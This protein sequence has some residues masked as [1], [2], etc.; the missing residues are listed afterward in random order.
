MADIITLKNGNSVCK[1][2]T[3]GAELISYSVNGKEKIWQGGG[4]FWA[5]KSP[6]LFPVC[7]RLV[8]G[9][10]NYEGNRYPLNAHG[11]IR[12]SN[13][14]VV[15]CETQTATFLFE[16]NEDTLKIYPFE[17]KFRVMY[18]LSKTSLGVYFIIENHSKVDMYYSAGC[19]EGYALSGDLSEYALSFDGGESEIQNTILKNNFTT[20]QKE[21]IKLVDGTL[22]L[23]DYFTQDNDGDSLII[24]N[25]NSKRVTLLRDGNEEISVYFGDFNHLVLWTQYGAPF[26]AIEPW[27]GLPDAVDTNHELSE[28]LSIEKLSPNESKTLYHSITVIE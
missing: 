19:H 21:S 27:N 11:F 25:V 1:I 6:I 12:N 7:G 9:F 4:K 8:D 26:F 3:L 18:K 2:S 15:N 22:K 13:F 20:T 14:S 24:E 10:Y 16:S 23:S 17:F 5:G 28:K